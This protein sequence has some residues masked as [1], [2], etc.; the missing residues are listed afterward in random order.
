MEKIISIL[1]E[2]FRVNESKITLEIGMEDID[3]WD[4]LTHM[5]MIANLE[6]EFDFEFTTD[7]IMKM[8]T[9]KDVVN[10]VEE[11]LKNANS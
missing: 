9:V 5:E 8:I 2:T 4:S 1:A 7:E 3:S 11:K 6:S 10:V